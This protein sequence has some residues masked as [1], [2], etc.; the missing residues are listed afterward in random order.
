MQPPF[1][2]KGTYVRKINPFTEFPNYKPTKLESMWKAAIGEKEEAFYV[3]IWFTANYTVSPIGSDEKTYCADYSKNKG[4]LLELVDW[5]KNKIAYNAAYK[6]V[7][8]D[9]RRFEFGDEQ[10]KF[11]GSFSEDILNLR[12]TNKVTGESFTEQLRYIPWL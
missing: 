10:R 3:I 2:L 4:E 5:H 7:K 6:N 1:K 8:F 9:E 11:S 12:I